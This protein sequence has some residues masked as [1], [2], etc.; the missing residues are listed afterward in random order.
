MLNESWSDVGKDFHVLLALHYSGSGNKPLIVGGV[1]FKYFTKV[2]CGL[3]TFVY[4]NVAKDI[5]NERADKIAWSLIEYAVDVLDTNAKERGHLGGCN[6]IFLET[7][8][9]VCF[10]LFFSFFSQINLC[11]VFF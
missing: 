8:N 7:V 2:N 9:P 5:N 11:P 3:L 4:T 1:T 10:S 6:A